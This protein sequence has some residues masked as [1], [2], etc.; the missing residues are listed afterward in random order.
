MTIRLGMV[1]CGRISHAHAIAA[2][3]IGHD[4]VRF[5]A[6]SD[7][8]P[9]AAEA[10]A[11][12]YGCDTTYTDYVD[13]LK[14]EKLDGIVLATWPAQHLEQIR[15]ALEAG[16]AFILCEKALATSGADAIEIW[17]LANAAGATVVEG[18]MYLHHPQ[19]KKIDALAA[20]LGKIDWVRSCSSYYFPEIAS[21]SDPNRSWRF[22]T[23]AGG[24]VPWDLACYTVNACAHYA[25]QLPRRVVATGSFSETYGTINRI[26]GTIGYEGGRTGII[27]SSTAATFNQALE[28]HGNEGMLHSESVFTPPGDTLVREIRPRKAQHFDTI[29]HV[30]KSPL[31]PQDDMASFYCYQAQ[32]ESFLKV[33][34]G[35]SALLPPL[36]HSV[37]NVITIEALIKSMIDQIYVDVTI[38]EDLR[39]SWVGDLDNRLGPP[40]TAVG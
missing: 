14:A 29:N 27:E 31:P 24:G 2:G 15:A 4:K 25:A 18:F 21:G 33:M 13:M 28:I 26:F 38:D 9:E 6:C 7:I 40:P 20:T 12:T 35:E 19:I 17:R 32:L 5:T 3:R 1:G 30:V 39:R 37:V 23:E 34:A 8:K 10:F 16:H 36:S 11:R 22:R